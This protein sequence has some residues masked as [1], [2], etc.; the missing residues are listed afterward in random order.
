L[1]GSPLDQ[2]GAVA[3]NTWVEFDVTSAITGNGTYSFGLNS[4]STNIAGYSSKEGANDPQLVLMVSAD[5]MMA[6]ASF[7]PDKGLDGTELEISG[8]GFEQVTMVT[9]AGL[10][11]EFTIEDNTLIRVTAPDR[12]ITGPISLA[13]EIGNAN[14]LAVFTVN[15][16]TTDVALDVAPLSLGLAYPNPFRS[17]TRL[18]FALPSSEPVRLVVFDVQGRRVRTLADGTFEAGSHDV[19]W[20]A[21][22]EAGQ[23]VEPGMYLIQLEAAGV[24][25][26]RKVALIR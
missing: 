22:D 24:S 4:N 25:T 1:S 13:S 5:P 6:I 9:I 8:S 2:K 11:A 19:S 18:R 16:G 10:A 7:T 17:T 23:R 14:S 26:R 21:R 20:D 15:V 3:L 12:V